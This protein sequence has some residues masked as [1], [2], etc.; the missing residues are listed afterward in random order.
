MAALEL[1]HPGQ[2]GQVLLAAQLPVV[3]S[4]V[5]RIEGVEPDHVEGL[6]TGGSHAGHAQGTAGL[7]GLDRWSG[8]P[9][10]PTFRG[11]ENLLNFIT[12][13]M[14]SAGERVSLPGTQ[15]DGPHRRPALGSQPP[16]GLTVVAPGHE[17]IL[18]AA[19]GLVHAELRAAGRESG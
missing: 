9:T 16:A 11:R 1:L 8:L 10:A 19:V 12:W 4:R 3:T 6:G 18:K 17:D 15:R 14:Y 7:G 13:Y 2:H 5:P